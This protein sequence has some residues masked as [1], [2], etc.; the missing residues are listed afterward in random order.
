MSYRYR[1]HGYG[2]GY[3]MGVFWLIGRAAVVL[4][5]AAVLAVIALWSLIDGNGPAATSAPVA[6]VSTPT[7]TGQ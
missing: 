3:R 5:I 4:F 2:F 6:S 7:C 1:R